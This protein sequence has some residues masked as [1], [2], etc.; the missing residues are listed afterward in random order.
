MNKSEAKRSSERDA[1]LL[2]GDPYPC[3]FDPGRDR[4]RDAVVVRAAS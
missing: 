3:G 2:D 4:H 1:R